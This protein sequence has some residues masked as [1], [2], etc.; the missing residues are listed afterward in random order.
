MREECEPVCG[1][2]E[3]FVLIRL[4]IDSFLQLVYPASLELWAEWFMPEGKAKEW[5]EG[6][7]QAER[8]KWL[9]EEVWI[10]AIPRS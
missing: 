3:A 7:R 9:T 8:P 4:Q 10:L 2:A 5:I 6:N 1:I